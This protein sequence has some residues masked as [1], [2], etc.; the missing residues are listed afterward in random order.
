[1][2]VNCDL[3][4]MLLYSILHHDGSLWMQYHLIG[5]GIGLYI[6]SP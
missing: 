2:L 4:P 5:V 6:N 3:T 1:M